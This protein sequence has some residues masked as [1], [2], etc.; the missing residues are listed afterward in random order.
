MTAALD[1][2]ANTDIATN[3]YTAD[4]PPP[5]RRA[6]PHCTR[7]LRIAWLTARPC[8][9]QNSLLDAIAA[10]PGIEVEVLFCNGRTASRT[11]NWEAVGGRYTAR[12]LRGL[13]YRGYHLNPGVIPSCVRKKY[14]LFIVTSYAQPTMQLAM[15]ALTAGGR[16]WALWA[17]RP[18]MNSL[19]RG[20][21]ILRSLGLLLPSRYADCVIGIGELARQ[22]F[23]HL[24]EGRGRVYSLPYLVRLEPFLCLPPRDR[25]DRQIR[26][27]FS[28]QLIPRKGIDLLCA[29]AASVLEKSSAAHLVVAGDGPERERIETLSKRF[30]G[31]VTFHGGL[32]FDQR[33]RAYAEADV[34]AF[35]SRHDGWGVA[36]QEAMAR[37][38]PVIASSE[39]G[40]A[41]DLVEDGVN[42][43]VLKPDDQEGLEHAMRVFVDQPGLIEEY[44]RRAR[45]KAARLTPEWG[46][47]QLFEILADLQTSK[48][49]ATDD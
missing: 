27:L 24:S 48:S 31:R 42:G 12:V 39:V 14:D 17:E 38:L 23:E 46:A 21:S 35:P 22:A 7:T 34:F 4:A 47:Q 28:G 45:A 32:P 13:T 30:P 36:L 11:W 8:P 19:S 9:L 43:F 37:G 18:G 49:A 26:F 5:N 16:P 2:A 20:R 41:Y 15:L 29:A 3:P 10:H 33:V 6:I 44:G 1:T 25:A 40:A